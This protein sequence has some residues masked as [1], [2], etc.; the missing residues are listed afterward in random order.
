MRHFAITGIVT[1]AW[2]PSIIAGSLMR[3][4]PP[5]R[6]MSAGTRSSA[7]TA[8]APASSAILRL[9]GG[10]DVHD[11]A[12]AQHLGEAP[13]HPRAVPV[14]AFG[15]GAGRRSVI[16][17]GHGTGLTIRSSWPSWPVVVVGG[18]VVGG[19]VVGGGGGA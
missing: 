4:T 11:H 7:I 10:D 5:S 8:T 14:V 12:A 13:L 9:L 18:T 16:A 15:H 2:M 3:A 6:R 1:A 19:A 17:P